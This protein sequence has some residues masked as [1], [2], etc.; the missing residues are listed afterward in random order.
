MSKMPAF[1]DPLRARTRPACRLENE[2]SGSVLATDVVPAFDSASRRRGLLKHES[3]PEGSALVIA[4]TNAIHTFF[5]KFAIDVVF[6]ARD[7]TVVSVRHRLEPWR[8]AAAWRGFAVIE[9]PSGVLASTRTVAGDR[10]RLV[11]S[12]RSSAS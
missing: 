10:L 9:L 1:L 2:R 4:P 5:M 7:G 3:M 8:I 11:V 12:E 6:V